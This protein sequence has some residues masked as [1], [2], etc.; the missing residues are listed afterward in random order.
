MK[1]ISEKK[2]FDIVDKEVE[3]LKCNSDCGMYESCEY[4]EAGEPNLENIDWEYYE[5]FV[6]NR[7]YNNVLKKYRI[8]YKGY[9]VQKAFNPAYYRIY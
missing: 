4:N 7:A 9:N 8:K 1:Y 2:F 5:N 3:S 6:Y